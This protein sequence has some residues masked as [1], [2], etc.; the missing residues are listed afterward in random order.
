VVQRNSWG[1][2][3]LDFHDAAGSLSAIPIDWTDRAAPDPFVVV[4][5]G[6]CHLRFEDLLR[7]VGMVKQECKAKD[8]A[9]V[10]RTM[11]RTLAREATGR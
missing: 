3:W 2:E 5:A 10:R 8:T 7:L 11:P 6:R 9:S 1:R 4:A